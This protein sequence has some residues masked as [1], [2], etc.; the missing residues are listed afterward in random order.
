MRS[1][2]PEGL[3][4]VCDQSAC[5]DTAEFLAERL[6]APLRTPGSSDVGEMPFVLR[7][8]VEGISLAGQGME[9]RP[10]LSKMIPRL[11][12]DRLSRELLVRAARIRGCDHPR[13]VDATAGLG[14]D[15]LL[16]A[17]AGFSVRMFER[18]P[19][20]EVLLEDALARAADLPELAEA[21]SRM[22]LEEADAIEALGAMRDEVELV[23]LDPMFPSRTKSSA[24]KKKFQLMHMLEGPCDDQKELLAAAL[25]AASRKVV[26][27]RP[28]K[29]AY[30][31]GVMPSYSIEGKAVR[32]DCISVES[33]PAVF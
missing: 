15:S 8:G 18:N 16:L 9:I 27:K 32:Y 12:K 14:E 26:V 6:H 19:V 4:V 11:R 23:Y 5:S 10:D 20:V 33:A 30:L 31:A 29:G 1:G 2:A 22:S 21:M 24:V 17:A 28:S 7:V 25:G 3:A 13:A